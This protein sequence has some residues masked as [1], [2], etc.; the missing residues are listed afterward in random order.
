MLSIAV[1]L[2]DLCEVT[3][4]IPNLK[5]EKNQVQRG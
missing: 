4:L 5:E 3:T 1:I 2:T